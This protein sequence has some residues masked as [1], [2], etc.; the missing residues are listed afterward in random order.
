M[1]DKILN[2][3]SQDSSEVPDLLEVLAL[4]KWYSGLSEEERQKLYEYSTAFG[5]GG[6]YNQLDQPVQSTTKTNKA[7]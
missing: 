1:I 5:A 6:E 7:T 3:L 2:V 4:S